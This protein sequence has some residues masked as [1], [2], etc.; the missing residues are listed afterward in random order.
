M[1][2]NIIEQKP[3]LLESSYTRTEICTDQP[4]CGENN[5]DVAAWTKTGSDG[6]METLVFAVN[7]QYS[8]VSF[9]LPSIN[10][11]IKEVLFGNVTAVNST[12]QFVI[13]RTGIAGVI[14]Q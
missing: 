9:T 5:I 4:E 3:F 11:T 1:A 7:Q 13:P 12:V 8:E 2:K 10:G 6:S 14:F